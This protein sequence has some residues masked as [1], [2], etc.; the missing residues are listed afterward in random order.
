MKVYGKIIKK[1]VKVNIYIIMM[2]NLKVYLKKIKNIMEMVIYI[3]K[4]VIYIMDIQRMVIK[5]VKV[6]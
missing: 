1:K 4:M 2:I 3:M 5:K 6:K